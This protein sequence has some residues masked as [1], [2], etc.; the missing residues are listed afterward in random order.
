MLR[1]GVVWCTLLPYEKRRRRKKIYVAA[2]EAAVAVAGRCLR[3]SLESLD[4][5]ISS[6]AEEKAEGRGAAAA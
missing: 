1:R 2:A 6:A 5:M 4:Q 3:P